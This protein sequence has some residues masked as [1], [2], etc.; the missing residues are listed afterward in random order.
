MHWAAQSFLASRFCGRRHKEE[1]GTCDETD[2]MEPGGVWSDAVSCLRKGCAFKLD[3]GLAGAEQRQAEG[4]AGLADPIGLLI[5]LAWMRRRVEVVKCRC[6]V[7]AP[8]C[9]LVDELRQGF[10]ERGHRS[11]GLRL[12]VEEQRSGKQRARMRRDVKNQYEI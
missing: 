2:N 12:I 11:F 6:P 9:H 10:L 8:L 7:F 3:V 4:V 5:A 1:R